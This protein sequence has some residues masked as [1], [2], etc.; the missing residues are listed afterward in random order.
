MS[1]STTTT[2][3]RASTSTAAVVVVVGRD[4]S[5]EK[6]AALYYC[7]AYIIQTVSSGGHVIILRRASHIPGISH[8][9]C[10][11]SSIELR[12]VKLVVD[13]AGR[14][15]ARIVSTTTIDT[16][17]ILI[18][19]AFI[20]GRLPS[21]HTWYISYTSRQCSS[22]SLLCAPPVFGED[23]YPVVPSTW[24]LFYSHGRFFSKAL[25]FLKLAAY[26]FFF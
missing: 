22:L 20:G 19:T 15:S 23:H 4:D 1:S 2:R 6:H 16:T 14:E 8:H 11:H 24:C 13:R 5:C 7:A 26:Q 10:I 12:D 9:V 17:A 25:V 18:S 21:C 3:Q